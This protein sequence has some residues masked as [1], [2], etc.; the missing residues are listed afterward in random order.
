MSNIVDR[1]SRDYTFVVSFF[2][3]SEPENFTNGRIF[4][5]TLFN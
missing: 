1:K 5:R 2:L 4:G 3:F